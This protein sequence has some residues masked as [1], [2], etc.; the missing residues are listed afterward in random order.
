[1]DA[2]FSSK[3]IDEAHFHLDGFI[4]RQNCRVW[5]S[6]NPRVINEKQMHPQGVTVWCGFWAGGIIGPYFFENDAAT[7]NGVQYRDIG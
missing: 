6:E 3:I 7:V 1:M 4:N 5:G 2:G